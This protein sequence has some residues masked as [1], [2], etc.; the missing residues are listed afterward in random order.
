MKLPEL[1]IRPLNYDYLQI[2]DP[3][4][5]LANNG[6]A[7]HHRWMLYNHTAG[8]PLDCEYCGYGP[9][10]WRGGCRVAVNVDHVNNIKGDD[11][12]ENLAPSCYWCNLFKMSWGYAYEEWAEA[13]ARYGHLPPAHRPPVLTVLVEQLGITPNDILYNNELTADLASRT[14]II[15]RR[16]SSPTWTEQPDPAPNATTVA[17]TTINANARGAAG[18]TTRLTTTPHPHMNPPAHIPA[19]L[20]TPR[21][22]TRGEGS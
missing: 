11:R 8:K 18:A 12:I 13:V 9:L 2:K 21:P 4:H 20:N 14:A 6:W 22:I 10:P 3:T 5:P 16:L 1:S 17:S 19:P 15:R 7:P